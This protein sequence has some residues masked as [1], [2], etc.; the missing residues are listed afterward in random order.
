MQHHDIIQTLG[1]PAKL[2]EALGCHHS[3][4]VRWKESGIPPRRWK[5]VAQVAQAAGHAEITVAALAA[6]APDGDE[7]AQP[8]QAA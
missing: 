5:A 6:A 7:T 2:A 1:G 8:V 4:P 3:Q